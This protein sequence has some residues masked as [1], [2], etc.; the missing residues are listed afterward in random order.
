MAIDAS[1]L[2][3]SVE[4][5]ERWRRRM[6]VTV[7]A[8]IVQE[9]EQKA[10]RQ[11]ASRAKLKGFRKGHVP[12][13]VIE[14]RF[15]GALRQEA[16]DK[17][18]GDAYRQALATE[19]LRPISEGQIGDVQ[20]APEQDLKFEVEFDVQPQI[21][22][23][24]LGGFAVE[25]PAAEVGDEQV[26][27]V[28]ERIQE[29][30]GAWQPLEEGT[31]ED[32]DLVSVQLTKL[33]DDEDDEA[34]PYDFILGKGDAIPDIE[35]AIKTLEPGKQDEFDITFPGA[36]NDPES[37]GTER[38]KIGLTALRRLERPPLDDDLAKQV[39]DFETLDELTT[40]VREDLQKEADN[41][42]EGAVRGRLL[43]F[44]I[45]ANPFEVPASMVDRYVE[46]VLS[47]SQDIPDERLAE[48]RTQIRPEAERA[49]KRLLVIDRV[50]ETQGLGATEEDLDTRIEEIAA[51]N[52]TTAAK[53]Y[54]N[55]QKSGRL[56][57]LERDLTERKVF[58]FLKE[59]SEIT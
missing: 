23:S 29:Q 10:A 13:R 4:E 51:A 58:E 9:E 44:L 28:L 14:S 47:D 8:T 32:G 24:R 35:A 31:P 25:R 39:G 40:R 53:V 7:P 3:I 56:D 55:M 17:L 26:Q 34:R 30:N 37:G 18:I 50:A 19:Q 49:V 54:A 46:G 15:S 52:E 27:Q 42:A 33:G 20:Y 11:L 57:A 43:E 2:Q 59:Q 1:R 6:S 38:V 5:Q 41:Q 22:L 36:A 12:T 16:L 48:V 45:D 21:E